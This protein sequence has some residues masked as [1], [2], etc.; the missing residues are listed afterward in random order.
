MIFFD[1]E[2]SN[3]T[4]TPKLVQILLAGSLTMLGTFSSLAEAR[5]FSYKDRRF[6]PFVRGSLGYSQLQDAAF[7]DSSGATTSTTGGVTWNYG[8]ELGF[9]LGLTETL[10]MRI[11]AEVIS[12]KDSDVKGASPAGVDWMTIDSSVFVFNPNVAFE[13]YYN[14]INNLRFFTAVSFGMANFTLENRYD[15]TPAGTTAN[16]GKADFI[17]KAEAN[18]YSAT[19]SMGL[20]TL[21]TDNVTVLIDLGYR[22]LE[23]SELKLKGNVNSFGN[24]SG[25]K[26]D[27]L[28]NADGS[29]RSLDLGGFYTSLTFRFYLNF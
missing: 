16:G 6:A 2:F 9:A 14:Q 23:A 22:Y 3:R 15:L 19:A 25:A 10:F 18:T 8:G 4:L 17:E 29:A 5:V 12:A 7:A 27:V 1:S 13:Y 21:F 24:P 11:G 26:G 20:E 28:K